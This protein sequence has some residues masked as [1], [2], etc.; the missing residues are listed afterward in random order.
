[1]PQYIKLELGTFVGTWN[2]NAKRR[3][4]VS[5]NYR[6]PRRAFGVITTCFKKPIP[7]LITDPERERR[8]L[9]WNTPKAEF[10]NP[11]TFYAPRDLIAILD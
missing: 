11:K 5:K 9:C 3:N 4:E 10:H 8:L 1:M 7:I 6:V 2:V